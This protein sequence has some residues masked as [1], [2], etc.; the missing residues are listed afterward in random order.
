[1]RHYLA[2]L[3]VASLP[4]GLTL[5]ALAGLSA[6]GV[7]SLGAQLVALTIVNAAATAAR[8]VLLRAWV[9]RPAGSGPAPSWPTSPA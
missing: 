1:M 7:T 3:I 4:L 5:L 8:F 9:F 2:G 6:T